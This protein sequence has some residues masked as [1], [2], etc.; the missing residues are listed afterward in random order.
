ML[1]PIG[2]AKAGGRHDG[3]PHSSCFPRLNEAIRLY[4]T[5]KKPPNT[6]ACGAHAGS[7]TVHI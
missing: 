1:A 3:T 6:V 4:Q 5:L 2:E 7:G